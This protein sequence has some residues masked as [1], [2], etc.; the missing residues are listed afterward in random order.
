V[1]FGFQILPP[2]GAG[3]VRRRH[4]P[5]SR[6]HGAFSIIAADDETKQRHRNERDGLLAVRT[7]AQQ[8]AEA[9]PYWRG[10]LNR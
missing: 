5:S 10:H 8:I 9:N 1:D 6:A 3:I 2:G 7:V 4:F